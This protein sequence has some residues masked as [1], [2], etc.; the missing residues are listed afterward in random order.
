M[1]SECGRKKEPHRLS[2]TPVQTTNITFDINN[3]E[4][5]KLESKFNQLMDLR[6]SSTAGI[7]SAQARTE[8]WDNVSNI[9]ASL[10]EQALVECGALLFQGKADAAEAAGV[11]TLRLRERFFGPKDLELVPAYFHL[12]RVKQYMK[13]Y[14]EA[15]EMLLLAHFLI[16]K[17]QEKVSTTTKAELHQTYG[18]LYASDGKLDPAIKHLSCAS[19]YFSC[20]YG[21]KHVLTTFSYF[22][23]GNVFAANSNIESSMATYD[24]IKEIWYEHLVDVLNE[25]IQKKKESERFK[26]YEDEEEIRKLVY[27]SKQEFG[28]ENLA[29]ASKMLYGIHSIQKERFRVSHPTPT[30]SQFILGL[31]LLW[32]ED[33][34]E[35]ELHMIE[36]RKA[37]QVFYGERH[38]VVT[39][40]EGWCDKFDINY[41]EETQAKDDSESENDEPEA[42]E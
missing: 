8:H 31:F 25:I 41:I 3:I 18:L 40:I 42:P 9:I 10:L 39:E 11:Q 12:A 24:A 27:A 30:R 20:M 34:G 33:Y 19:Y 6:S 4:W 37:S 26:K 36:A 22:D 5:S 2:L 15:E 7:S 21:P 13:K 17:N 29:V 32:I 1:N 16:L 23:L 14:A 35:A 28:D 38:P